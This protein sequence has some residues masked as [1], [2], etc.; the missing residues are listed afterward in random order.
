MN[1]K[2]VLIGNPNVGKSVIFGHLTGSYVTVSNYPGTTVEIAQGQA[3]YDSSRDVVIDTPGV[4]SLLPF[5]EDE[6]VTRDILLNER[7]RLVVQV[8]DA[9]NLRRALF[10]SV[11]LAEMGIPFILN[12]NMMDEAGS[13]GIDLDE[14]KL[15]EILGVPVIKSVAIHK[16]GLLG[17]VNEIQNG[18]QPSKLTLTYPDEIEAGVS[19]LI[20]Y[21]PEANTSKRAVAL[22][23]L[24]GDLS[25]KE[26]LVTNLDADTIQKIEDIILE[27]QSKLEHYSIGSAINQQR[28]QEAEGILHSVYKQQRV[29]G[30]KITELLSRVSM[31][32]IWGL[33]ILLGVLYAMYQFVGVFGAGI[34]VDFF[35]EV[36]FGKFVTPAAERLFLFLAPIHLLHELLVGEYGLI[37]MALSYAVA[38]VLPVVATFFIAFSLLED[39]GYL[40]RLAVMMNRIFRLLGLHGKAVLPMVLGLGCDTM[41]T[42]T[43]RILETRKERILVTL[44][45]ALGIPCSAQLGVILGLLGGLSPSAVLIWLLCVVGVLFLVGYLA[46]K[47]LPGQRSDF[48]LELPPI[49]RPSFMNIVTKTIARIEWYLKEAVPLFFL[50]TLVLFVL[51]K[52]GALQAIEI[53][54]APLISGFLGLPETTAEAFLIGF[55]RRDYGAAG[56]F[57]MARQGLLNPKQIVVSLVTITLFVPCIANFFVIIKE[58][59]W[60][61]ALAISLFIIPFAFLVGG[62]LNFILSAV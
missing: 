31:H 58:R 14:Q 9:K 16:R 42:L 46:S 57:D 30:K 51:A 28:L 34:L 35:E 1:E 27:V 55:L 15:S 52:T 62:I 40:P 47:V 18:T 8:A 11:Q 26:W 6:V 23:L 50:G 7:P 37:T 48:I 12:L 22:M 3:K 24:S 25:L 49:R 39:S 2:I 61:T 53:W 54:T 44:L 56:L 60:K 59:G 33:P 19:K 4:N 38:I 20:P 32:P 43:T 17:L 13:R 36:I 5:S 41:A 29:Q 45:L 21:L 10:L